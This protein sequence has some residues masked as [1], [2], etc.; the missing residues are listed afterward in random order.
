MKR[1]SEGVFGGALR[2]VDLR[3]TVYKPPDDARLWKPCDYMAWATP[4]P[5]LSG[6]MPPPWTAW[7]EVKDVDAVN[8]FS[9][10]ELRPSQLQGMHE[11]WRVGIPYWLAVWWRRHKSWTISNMHRY[12]ADI[13]EGEVPTSIDRVL[14]MSR[15]GIQSTTGQL[16]STLKS[17]L[18]GEV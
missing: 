1:G 11:A 10:R 16:A 8:A 6:V 12:K 9:L 13:P 4:G 17:V 14:L 15:Y 2:Q 5:D 18:L 7:F 3:M